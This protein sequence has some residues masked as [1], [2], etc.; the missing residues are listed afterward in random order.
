MLASIF[1]LK[2]TIYITIQQTHTGIC[3]YICVCVNKRFAKNVYPN[4][5]CSF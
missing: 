4:T 1:D 2:Y 3:V 5:E